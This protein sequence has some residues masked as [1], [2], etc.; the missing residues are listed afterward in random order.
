MEHRRGESPTT[1]DVDATTSRR[2]TSD[3]IGIANTTSDTA[4]AI[5]PGTKAPS[6]KHFERLEACMQEALDDGD[7]FSK[8]QAVSILQGMADR[9]KIDIVVA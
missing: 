7:D 3:N 2:L 9:L 4:Y 5:N 1:T 6:R 8:R